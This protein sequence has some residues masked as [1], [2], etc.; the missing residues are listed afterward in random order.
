MAQDDQHRHDKCSEALAE[1]YT[2]LDGELTEARRLAIRSHLDGCAP[3]FEA[4]DFE[5]ELRLVI[6]H[7]CRDEVPEPLR[8]RIAALLRQAVAEQTDATGGSDGVPVE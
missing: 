1:L 6:S 3:C 7:R 8:D 5:A 4:F 2:F